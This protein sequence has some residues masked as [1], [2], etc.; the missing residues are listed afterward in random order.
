MEDAKEYRFD[1]YS[2]N[3][4]KKYPDLIM[5]LTVPILF[6]NRSKTKVAQELQ[7]TYDA[8]YDSDFR[9]LMILP[10]HS[11]PGK[12]NKPTVEIL[13]LKGIDASIVDDLLEKMEIKIK[14]FLDEK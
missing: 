10:Y 2:E 1:R 13:N 7:M 14:E 4:P 3:K 8:F 12:E 5:V 9:S 11:L 6:N